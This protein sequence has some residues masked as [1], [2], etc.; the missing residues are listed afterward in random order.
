MADWATISSLATAGGTLVL[1]VATFAS[2]RSAN[3]SARVAERSLLLGLRPVLIPTY[4]S[5][6][7]EEIYFGDEHSFRLHGANGAAEEADGNVYLAIPLRNV[8]SG[9]AVLHGWHLQRGRPSAGAPRPDLDRF[10]QQYRDLYIPAGDTGY[11]QGGIRDQ[12]DPFMEDARGAV[13]ARE[14]LTIDLLYGDW[15]GG[16]RT[17]SRFFMTHGE[18]VDWPVRVTRHWSVE[19]AD[20][21][22]L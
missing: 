19:G 21:R 18:G 7:P 15:E 2:V 16:Q 10:R 9:L 8:G 1:A 6:R 13:L 4:E 5:D 17:I 20:P 12:N 3:R 22:P 14:P 11:W